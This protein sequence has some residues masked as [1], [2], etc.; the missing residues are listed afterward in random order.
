MAQGEPKLA[1]NCQPSITPGRTAPSLGCPPQNSGRSNLDQNTISQAI[2]T[3][4]CPTSATGKIRISATPHTC[5]GIQQPP[6]PHQ[7]PQPPD[8]VRRTHEPRKNYSHT[9]LSSTNLHSVYSTQCYV[10]IYLRFRNAMFIN[11]AEN[12]RRIIS[13]CNN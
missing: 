7:Q 2:R 13:Y 6:I 4:T 12:C 8:L 3:T 10:N 5:L 11:V 9:S 1:T